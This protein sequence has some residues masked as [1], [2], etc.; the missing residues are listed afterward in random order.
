[1]D[2]VLRVQTT[3]ICTLTVDWDIRTH[4]YLSI[5][6]L[7]VIKASP[8]LSLPDPSPVSP[9][10]ILPPSLPASPCLSLPG[11]SPCL[12]L[13]APQACRDFLDLAELQ[14]RRWHRALQHERE[15]RHHLEETI[16]QLAKQ[17]NCLERALRDPPITRQGGGHTLTHSCLATLS[18]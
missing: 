14:S 5:W 12:S 17:H 11:P 9:C 8:C 15:Q 16:E 3:L 10:L 4:L 7:N 13:P 18:P 6:A 1:M 2:S